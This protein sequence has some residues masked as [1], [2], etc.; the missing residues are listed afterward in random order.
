MGVKKAFCLFVLLIISLD[1]KAIWNYTCSSL[2][3]DR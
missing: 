3:S 2:L 1:F